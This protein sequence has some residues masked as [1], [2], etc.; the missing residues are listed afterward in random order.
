MSPVTSQE[1][2]GRL[3]RLISN[4]VG[5]GTIGLT[6]A[7]LV[8]FLIVPVGL[9]VVK[10]FYN[11]EEFTLA[12]FELLFDN[13]LQME[14]IW[15]SLCIGL[16]TTVLT[17]LLALPLAIVNARFEFR[18]KALLSG[19]LLVPMVM[20]PFVGAIGILRFFA[21]R[22]SVNLQF[23]DWGWIDTPIEWLAGGNVF[24]AVVILEVLHLYPIM[25]LNL[26]AALANIDPSLE[27]VASTLG[28]PR[29]KQ[30]KDVVWPL[31]RPGYFAGAI[32]VFIWALTDL[33]T[34]L[35]V[36]YEATMPV[37]IFT[38]VTDVNENPMGFALV[39]FVIVM[40]VGIF[41]L[42]KLIFSGRKY[43]MMAR[44]H[45]TSAVRIPG[46]AGKLLIYSLLIGTVVVALVPHITVL[47]TSVSD[48]WFMTVLPEQYTGR[49]YEMVFQTE[50]SL[51]GIKNSLMLSTASMMLDVI[52]GLLI[53]YVVVRKLIPM[54]DLLDS[55]VMVPLALPGIV[56]AFGYVVTYTD[57]FLDPLENPIPLLIIA[58]G[59]RRLPF[60]VRSAAAGLQQTSVSLEE[61]SATFGASRFHTLRKII[62]PLVFANL[63]AGGLLCFAY[64]MLD[65]SDSLILAMKDRYYPITKAIYAL[66]LEAG[67]GEFIASALGMIGMLILTA[68]ILGASLILGKKM[69][70]LFRSA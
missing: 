52:L 21:R 17:T 1:D 6:L 67:S 58:Y 45:V 8:F 31:S 55:L 23:M 26:T 18:G 38:L 48:R 7:M 42:S 47:I 40:T 16:S 25:Y 9:I 28:V 54:A 22:G 19:L 2:S 33:G 27:E 12:Y 44:G 4:T 36:G 56:L 60:M 49:Y 37:R 14:S 68:C 32:I 61:A 15:N 30:L 3:R 66:F 69:G 64:A 59:I 13:D 11:G 20:P 57:T 53:A 10:A 50:L 34:P 51:T 70:E 63:V 46:A 24:W 39:F 29:W 5:Y 65:V 62:M 35:L 43:E 41:L